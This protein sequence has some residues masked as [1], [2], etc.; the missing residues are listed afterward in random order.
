VKKQSFF[1]PISL[2]SRAMCKTW[3]A[4]LL[5]LMTLVVVTLPATRAGGQISAGGGVAIRG[6]GGGGRRSGG[7]GIVDQWA[8]VQ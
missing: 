7:Y 4:N 5:R 1:L 2:S 8:K 3:A 6:G